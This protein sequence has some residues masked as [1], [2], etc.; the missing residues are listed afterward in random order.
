MYAAESDK[1]NCFLKLLLKH[2]NID[3]N[4]RK[5][6]QNPTPLMIAATNLQAINLRW[7]LKHENISMN[8][9][10]NVGQTPL[11]RFVVKTKT[12]QLGISVTCIRQLLN[13]NVNVINNCGIYA[14]KYNN[15]NRI[16]FI[17]ALLIHGRI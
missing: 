8:C 6:A 13:M 11:L 16:Y 4:A 1:N 5:N 7:L 17:Y 3:V 9:T 14:W 2:K 15:S 10:N 12:H